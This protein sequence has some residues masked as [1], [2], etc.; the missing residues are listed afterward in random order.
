M[1]TDANNPVEFHFNRYLTKLEGVPLAKLVFI[2]S[3]LP[4]AHTARNIPNQH[5]PAPNSKRI[6]KNVSISRRDLMKP[7]SGT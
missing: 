2:N 5:S 1:N 4:F 7:D 3:V 6:S